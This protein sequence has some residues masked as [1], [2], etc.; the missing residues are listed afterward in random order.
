MMEKRVFRVITVFFSTIDGKSCIPPTM[1]NCLVYQNSTSCAKCQNLFW[2][3]LG[4]CFPIIDQFCQV[5]VVNSDMCSECL[6]GYTLQEDGFCALPTE[7]NC[8]IQNPE[9]QTCTFCLEGYISKNSTDCVKSRVFGCVI[10]ELN[11]QNCL[12]CDFRKTLVNSSTCQFTN[13]DMRCISIDDNNLCAFC[14][15]GYTLNEKNFC[16][17]LTENCFKFDKTKCD[18]CFPSFHLAMNLT[19]QPDTDYY[20]YDYDISGKC[21]YCYP[22]S[23]LTASGICKPG[24][25]N[26][27]YFYS[28]YTGTCTSC[29]YGYYLVKNMC[30]PLTATPCYNSYRDINFCLNCFLGYYVVNGESCVASTLV[31]NCMN[32]TADQ[33]SCSVCRNGFHLAE[34]LT[35]EQNTIPNCAS[36]QVVVS[37]VMCNRCFEGYALKQNKCVK[38]LL[39][40]CLSPNEDGSQ[41]SECQPGFLLVENAG[42]LF[43]SIPNC[44]SYVSTTRD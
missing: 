23:Y 21:A 44:D 32:Y 15:D 38:N 40:N 30:L 22:E 5:S 20:C 24:S 11:T 7:K 17:P 16:V 25:V 43:G 9:D 12:L 13:F 18:Y 33:N 14:E 36:E 29:K 39:H 4:E 37:G 8:R 31:Q 3:Y 28:S 26:N 1:E 35:C 19:C 34:G 2:L 6:P 10:N 41:C 42:C 27:C